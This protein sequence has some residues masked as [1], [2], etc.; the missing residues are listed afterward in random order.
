MSPAGLAHTHLVLEESGEGSKQD[1]TKLI[2][3]TCTSWVWLFLNG[4]AESRWYDR[5]RREKDIDAQGWCSLDTHEAVGRHLS[6]SKRHSV[7]TAEH[8]VKRWIGTRV[9]SLAS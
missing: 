8:K 7:D 5:L 3:H 9:F 1:A 4:T 2:K 6:V